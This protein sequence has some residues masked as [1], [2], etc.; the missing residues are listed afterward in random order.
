M[1]AGLDMPK[2]EVAQTKIFLIK[3]KLAILFLGLFFYMNMKEL[4]KLYVN[5]RFSMG[6]S[7]PDSC[8]N[9]FVSFLLIH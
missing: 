6:V 1:F 5:P 8:S 4:G 2:Q 9:C 3:G 7:L